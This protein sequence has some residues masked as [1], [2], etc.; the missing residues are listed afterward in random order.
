M[1][2]NAATTL[3]AVPIGAGAKLFQ[4]YSG[5]AIDIGNTL[6]TLDIRTPGAAKTPGTIITSIPKAI[7]PPKGHSAPYPVVLSNVTPAVREA[8]LFQQTFDVSAR[9]A[10][11]II[12]VNPGLLSWSLM[13]VSANAHGVITEANKDSVLY[14][15]KLA[16]YHN[17]PFRTLTANILRSQGSGGATN[18]DRIRYAMRTF[19]L[20]LVPVEDNFGMPKPNYLLEG[21]PLSSDPQSHQQWV[22]LVRAVK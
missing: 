14:D 8:L 11:N 3:L 12:E 7:T 9:L 13:T 15:I 22:A 21:A 16:L 19:S 2:R 20:T 1:M 18:D 5:I 4:S 17:R 6:N 10:F